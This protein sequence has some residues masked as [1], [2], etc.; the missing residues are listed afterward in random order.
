M[1]SVTMM[2]NNAPGN[3]PGNRPL[4]PTEDKVAIKRVGIGSAFK[5]G[6]G[7]SMLLVITFGA[8]ALVIWIIAVLIS[9]TIFES[10]RS[11]LGS[12]SLGGITSTIV[13]PG[14]EATPIA[15]EVSTGVGSSTLILGIGGGCVTYIVAILLYGIVGGIGAAFYAFFYNIVGRWFGGIEV[16]LKR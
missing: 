16:E 5:M 7:L 14:T 1:S 3:M 9:P 15:N 6:C 11:S 12:S 10:V 8:I 13:A 4:Q 2:P